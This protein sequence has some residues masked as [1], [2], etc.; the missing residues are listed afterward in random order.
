MRWLW[1]DLKNNLL[2]H[3]IDLKFFL[4]NK[5]AFEVIFLTFIVVVIIVVVSLAI[6]SLIILLG[7]TIYDV[8]KKE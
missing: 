2:M 7:R 5:L 3:K 1:I 8:F 6:M 4:V